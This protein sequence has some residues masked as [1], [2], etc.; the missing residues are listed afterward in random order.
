MRN[1]RALAT[2]SCMLLLIG[3]GV[4]EGCRSAARTRGAGPAAEPEGTTTQR[5]GQPSTSLHQAAEVG[6]AAEV[7]RL[8]GAG[9]G[10]NA[11]NRLGKTALHLA[12]RSNQAEVVRLLLAH[13]AD[14]NANGPL[15]WRPLHTAAEWGHIEVARALLE[16][17]AEVNVKND[18]G[19]PPIHYAATSNPEL[20][21]LLRA[22]GAKE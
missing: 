19:C 21:E 16:H 9:A 4:L 10:P 18:V 5:G 7:K 22:H 17:G 12:S 1:L 2:L 3:S 14:A 11:E 8:L 13:G 6:D 15:G 20:G